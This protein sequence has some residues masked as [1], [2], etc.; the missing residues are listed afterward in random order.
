MTESQKKDSA[1]PIERKSFF[2]SFTGVDKHWAE[3]IGW[4]LEEAGYSVI[5]QTW[6]FHG[7]DNIIQK[8]N[9]AIKSS[10]RTILVISPDYEKS[11]YTALEWSATF[12]KDP[13]G[14]SGNVVPVIVR[15]LSSEESLGGL[16]GPI[17][18]IDLTGRDEKDARR[19][20]LNDLDRRRHKPVL[21]PLFP[22]ASAQ[23][24]PVAPPSHENMASPSFPGPAVEA[25]RT[26]APEANGVINALQ[27]KSASNTVQ[28][29][30]SC[31]DRDM[32]MCEKLKKQLAVY[33]R[34]GKIEVWDRGQITGGEE[35]KKTMR[36]K[37]GDARIVFLLISD[38]YLQD[39]KYYEEMESA[40]ALQD[41]KRVRV[42]PVSVR[43]AA[44]IEETA[45]KDL[46]LLPRD[47]PPVD[48]WRNKDQAW[49][50]VVDE[51]LRVLEGI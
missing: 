51:F 22:G 43:D 33:R 9:T 40:L 21:A 41:A 16:L 34:S 36:A 48:R 3:W 5:L 47:S 17:A 24:E 29:V 6:D 28:V 46:Q 35:M 37:L 20:L 15:S 50:M 32:D 23:P 31:S 25:D 45:L 26:V 10:E 18:F 8:I 4:E 19:K 27:Q 30:I 14:A 38:D 11:T 39:D 44:G 1:S 2:I 42:V 49:K 13:T 12:Y 7:G